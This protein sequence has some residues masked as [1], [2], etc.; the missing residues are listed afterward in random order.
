MF[1]EECYDS[2]TGNNNSVVKII[3]PRLEY[4]GI[5]TSK[6]NFNN[7]YENQEWY[8]KN[9]NSNVSTYGSNK[10]LPPKKLSLLIL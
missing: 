1:M 9:R 10:L 8:M 2:L 4:D 7:T 5:Y 6:R 3:K